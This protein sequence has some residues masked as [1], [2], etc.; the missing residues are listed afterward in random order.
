[1]PTIIVDGIE[2]E[3]KADANLLE[4][5]LSNGIDI[6]Y[7]CWHP[8]MGS[9]GACRQCA[10]L[11]YANEDD[12]RG[13]II[14]S[15]MTP[16]VDGARFSVAE[17]TA[18]QFRNSVIEN[19]MLNHPHDCPVCEEGGE[20]HLQDMTVMVGHHDRR[21]TGQKTTFRNQYLGPYIGHEM[22]RCITCYRCTRYYQDYAGGDDLSA[23]G[24]RDRVFFGRATPGLLDNEF[25]GNLVEVCPTGVFTDKTLSK[26]YTRKW[27]LQ[28]APTICQACSLGC[29]TYTSER[30]GEL[31]RVHN[32]YHNEINGYFL[33]DR[34]RF[35][36]QHVNSENRIP[37][38]GR[39][40]AQGKYDPISLAS[41]LEGIR[42]LLTGTV[43]GIGSPRASL[44]ANKA[45]RLLVGA[46]N[47][48]NGMTASERKMH[49]AI[50]DVLNS[51]L[52]TPSMMEVENY[53]A[54][55][56][57]GE[58][59]TNHAPR[60]ALS[61]RQAVRAKGNEMAGKIGLSQWH[62]AAVRELAQDDRSELI[63]L[64]PM[65]DRLDDVASESHRLAPNDIVAMVGQ[66]TAS[67]GS[68]EPSHA[69]DIA[70]ILINAKR[71]LIISGTSLGSTNIIKAAANLA[72]TLSKSNPAAGIHLCASEANSLGVSLIDNQA[73]AETLLSANP[74]TVIVLE[75]DV[76]SRFGAALL[77]GTANIVT[78]DSHD[79][80]TVSRSTYVL[81]AASFAESE[82]SFVNNEGRMQRSM[83][84]FSSTSDITASYR[85]LTE[86]NSNVLTAAELQQKI[87][88]EHPALA[89]ITQCAPDQNFRVAG[90]KVARMTHRASGRTAM[91]ADISVHEPK[92][93]VDAESAMAFTMEGNQK[94][95]PASLRSYTWS[96]GWNSNQSIHK[97]QSEVGGPD[98][99]EVPG[100]RIFNSSEGLPEFTLQDEPARNMIGQHHIFGSE[101]LTRNASEL[102]TLIPGM[103]ARMNS[104]TA[105]QLG[106]SAGDGISAN[107]ISMTV[108]IDETV[109]E[110]CVAY[111]LL[112]NAVGI[113]QLTLSDLRKI[114]G[115]QPPL[116][117]LRPNLIS[118]DR[119]G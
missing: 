86:I 40:N 74:D 76:E 54:I 28:S 112:G 106:V 9:V 97:F 88:S 39:R 67:I 59:V 37:Q 61:I 29:N 20:C 22:N 98:I 7:F 113:E 16:V 60:L 115:Y 84:V 80:A 34:G 56:V 109:A 24:S 23:F 33:C 73:D 111:P 10:V 100:I 116:D 105:N 6:P 119:P 77:E 78:L 55:L 2:I 25:A 3:A 13:R 90:S 8:A 103:Y 117:P 85:L 4:V 107:D 75:N 15:C 36:A 57:V 31:R 58:D 69:K 96:P 17:E 26:N 12:T 68:E 21:Y 46:D 99:T 81:P 51:G 104:K 93:P 65:Q 43:V 53:D 5:L 87:A 114:D 47:Y 108:L 71:P 42:T 79:N 52:N 32:R 27:D 95:A 50:L 118:S 62:D 91:L 102:A 63:V 44:E 41:A 92:Q 82:G 18:T 66:I 110:D 94:N 45:L 70:T 1:M 30:Y 48:C 72:A 14:M 35:G 83:A 64:T 89:A 11:G 49:G 19:L 38:S 101:E